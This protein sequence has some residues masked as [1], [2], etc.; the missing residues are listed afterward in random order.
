MIAKPICQPIARPYSWM[1]TGR[2]Q[3]ARSISVSG[4]LTD[5]TDPV[6]FPAM[7]Y[8]DIVNALPRFTDESN[9]VTSSTGSVWQLEDDAGIGA[10]WTSTADVASP[11]L[12]PAGAWHATENP[13]AWKPVSPATGTP[14]VTATYDQR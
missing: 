3:F 10:I 12:V 5:G 7:P 2:A 13:H 6:T 14:I 4:T 1:A 9:H 11:E 8:L